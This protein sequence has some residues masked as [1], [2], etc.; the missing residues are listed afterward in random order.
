MG[1]K[2]FNFLAAYSSD[3]ECVDR[4][5]VSSFLR[6]HG[7]RPVVNE[8][9]LNYWIDEECKEEYAGLEF[10]SSLIKIEY[11]A[12]E[13]E[14]LIKLF[15]FVISPADRIVNGA[16]YTPVDIRSFIIESCLDNAEIHPAA[17]FADIACGCG[18]FL[19]SMTSVIKALTD[20]PYKQIIEENI[21]GLDIQQYST[22]R[23]KLLLSVL[24][25]LNGED[26]MGVAYHIFTG[27]ALS[28]NWADHIEDFRGFSAIVGNPPYVSCR[29]LDVQT[30]ENL[31]NWSVAR[32]GNP[33]LYIPF[34]QIGME[35]MVEGGKLGFIT[36]NTFFKSLNGRALR[37]Y[38]QGRSF[39]FRI[40]DF[41]SLQVFKAKNTYTCI[42]LIAKLQSDT[43]SYFKAKSIRPDEHDI[44]YEHIPYRNLNALSGWNLDRH[45]DISLIE[46][47]G[48]PFGDIFKTRHG[49]ATLKNDIFIFRPVRED[50]DYYYLQADQEFKLEKGLC[51]DVVNSNKLSRPNHLAEL[52]EKIIFPYSDDEKP[53][54]LEENIL[55][56]HFPMAYSYLKY[57]KDV[58]LKRDKGKGE[59]AW[60][61]FGRTQSLDK[62]K[63]KLF[64]PKYSDTTPS[65]I[66]NTDPNLLFYNGLSV[67]A[68]SDRELLYAKR[69]MQS[70]LFWYYISST[71]K[72]YSSSY[73]SLNGNY[74]RHFG[75]YNFTDEEKDY[76]IN[77]KSQNE[78]DRFFEQKYK[79]TGLPRV[80]PGDKILD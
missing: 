53:K 65:F 49:I 72:P 60:Y 26:M 45:E 44:D 12:F 48:T 59:Y 34:F 78:L 40:I 21:F 18:G 47:T 20:R 4:I 46:A 62:M 5:I 70:S 55:Q 19:M 41:G 6:H 79:L 54:L 36:M 71:S 68:D 28:F 74:I 42:T 17:K 23:S 3:T 50:K 32:V 24:A 64:F 25:L 27:D 8:L 29:N 35:N 10:F 67:V 33:D 11:P 22:V 52:V 38:F 30:K 31:Q 58:L 39:S 14:D 69:I 7:L 56:E 63:Y 51:R 13:I 66:H 61:A 80:N 76:L 1:N 15:E 37:S 16:V 57:N 73:Y 75:V 77:I 9:L 2:I 43:I